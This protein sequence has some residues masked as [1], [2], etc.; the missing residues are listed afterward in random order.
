VAGVTSNHDNETQYS[1][2]VAHVSSGLA[3][4]WAAV[5]LAT[6]NR[7]RRGPSNMTLGRSIS[8]YPEF[9]RSTREIV[10]FRKK[11]STVKAKKVGC[12]VYNFPTEK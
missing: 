10:N 4:V 12:K 1:A 11:H 8:T 9:N 2:T 7:R 5:T 6:L 3:K